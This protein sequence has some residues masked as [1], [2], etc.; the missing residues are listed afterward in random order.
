MKPLKQRS[1]ARPD[2]APQPP[3]KWPIQGP[4][5]WFGLIL[6]LFLGVA[7]LKFGNPVILHSKVLPPRSLPEWWH[8]A[9][10]PGWSVWCLIPLIVVGVVLLI[11]KGLT[12]SASPALCF[13]PLIWFGWQCVSAVSSEDGALTQLTLWHFAGLIAVYF[14]GAMVLNSDRCVRLLLVGLL[15]GLVFC[16]LRAVDQKFFEF[17]AEREFLVQSEKSGWT[18]LPPN[19]FLE[20]KESGAIVT[21]NGVDIANPLILK[22]YENGRVFGT[23]VYPNALAGAILL[24]LPVMLVLAT[25]STQ[26]FRPLTRWAVLALTVFLGLGALFWSGSKSGWLIAV[27]LIGLALLR[28]AGSWRTKVVTVGLA[29]VIGGGLFALKFQSYFSRGATSV[30][31]RFDYW[32]AAVQTTRDHP[33]TGT[34]PGTFQHPYQRLKAPE[35][36]MARLTHNDYLEQFSDSGIVGGVTY[37]AWV[38]MLLMAVAR[39]CGTEAFSFR[40][41][42]FLGGVGWFLQGFSE[43]SLYVPALAWSAFLIMG[44]LVG[45]AGNQIDKSPSPA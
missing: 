5:E 12:W 33:W 38:A 25:R 21:T 4:I 22:K 34:G 39:Q 26:G 36:E 8:L 2:P 13:L 10:P 16:L 18:N 29:L 14:L 30:G 27:A 41:A 28:R 1:A 3:S 43:F 31:A 35:S 42:L 45:S 7:L 32:R 24:L 23:L 37:A 11:R 9:W 19:L 6:G 44:C 40:T 15:A 17:P 20:M